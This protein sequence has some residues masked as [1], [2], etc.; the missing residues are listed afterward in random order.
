MNVNSVMQ[1]C[2]VVIVKEASK[3][4][5]IVNHQCMLPC[6][7]TWICMLTVCVCVCLRVCICA[8]ELPPGAAGLSKRRARG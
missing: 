3:M 2:V 1:P 8:G 4:S 5:A 7:N 6:L